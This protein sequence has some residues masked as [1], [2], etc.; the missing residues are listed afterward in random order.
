MLTIL[1][2]TCVKMFVQLSLLARVC[3]FG[4]EMLTDCALSFWIIPGGGGVLC[5][6]GG[7]GGP[8][9][10]GGDNFMRG[11]MGSNLTCRS[12]RTHFSKVSTFG[13]CTP[14]FQGLELKIW[15]RICYTPLQ[16]SIFC[17]FWS[18]WGWGGVFVFWRGPNCVFWGYPI[19][20]GFWGVQNVW[21]CNIVILVILC[22]S[23]LSLFCYFLMSLL[24]LFCCNA[25]HCFLFFV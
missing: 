25:L 19:L 3:R 18:F 21:F 17:H 7:L 9:V 11:W 6:M 20:H 4:I 12:A 22:Y 2:S 14:H 8:P 23:I 1:V 16:R 15:G 24:L 5:T 13:V 10:P